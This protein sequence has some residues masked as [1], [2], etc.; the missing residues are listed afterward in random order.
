MSAF[1]EGPPVEMM[2]GAFLARFFSFLG[3]IVSLLGRSFTVPLLSVRLGSAGCL[4]GG[5]FVVCGIEATVSVSTVM[6]C[7]ELS[8]GVTRGFA[9]TRFDCEDFFFGKAAGAV[10][11]LAGSWRRMLGGGRADNSFCSSDSGASLVGVLGCLGVV[12]C[13]DAS[14]S[15]VTTV[16]TSIGEPDWSLSTTVSSFEDKLLAALGSLE[17]A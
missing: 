4:V 3:R 1:V 15:S 16:G 7:T 2:D 8:F 6:V 12:D 17:G 14:G 11:F 10:T 9:G 5:G 13:L